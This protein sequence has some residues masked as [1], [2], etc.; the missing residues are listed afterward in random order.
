MRSDTTCLESCFLLEQN[1]QGLFNDRI[2][3]DKDP[4]K[5]VIPCCET[6]GG[7]WFIQ[8]PTRIDFFYLNFFR[9]ETI[10]LVAF[11]LRPINPTFINNWDF[12]YYNNLY[13]NN[14]ISSLRILRRWPS[15]TSFTEGVREI[16]ILE[17][18]ILFAK[19]EENPWEINIGTIHWSYA[20]NEI[21][22]VDANNSKSKR[23]RYFEWSQD[24][25][26][27]A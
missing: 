5:V 23:H 16:V 17:W 4:W 1:P 2:A 13:F 14:I 7:C 3:K 18:Y 9:I 6:H 24:Q 12:P 22:I 11:Q 8:C 15:L 10:K 25:W 26:D 20:L 21:N 19:N 27:Q